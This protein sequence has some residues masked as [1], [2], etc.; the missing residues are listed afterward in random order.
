MKPQNIILIRHGQS[1]G[2]LNKEIYKSIPDYALELTDEGIEI[3][4]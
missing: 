2:N 4:H 3:G 1:H